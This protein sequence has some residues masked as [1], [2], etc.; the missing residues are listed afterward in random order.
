MLSIARKKV[1]EV[2][3][4]KMFLLIT[5]FFSLLFPGI[6]AI[7]YNAQS[8]DVNSFPIVL[9]PKASLV[10]GP[11]RVAVVGDS[12]PAFLSLSGDVRVDLFASRKQLDQANIDLAVKGYPF[13]FLF[14]VDMSEEP[15]ILLR[16]TSF[17]NA[18]YPLDVPSYLQV[19]Y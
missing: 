13:P 1:I 15:V 19:V 17:G 8:S 11:Y 2:T 16:N 4:N 6:L 18:S 10:S 14:G 5:I 7:I 12:V 3:Q 9:D